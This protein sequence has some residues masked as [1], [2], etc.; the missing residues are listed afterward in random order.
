MRFVANGVKYEFDD[1]KLTFAEGKALQ[2][3]TKM[4]LAEVQ[5]AV[6]KF[7]VVAVQGLVWVA[8]KRQDP[9]LR[10]ED[11]ED[12]ALGSFEFLEDEEIPPVEEQTPDPTD[13]ADPPAGSSTPTE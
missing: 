10:F 11:L 6:Q 3:K 4:T 1:T 5:E 8:M 13:A 12:E 2:G 9:T 7:D